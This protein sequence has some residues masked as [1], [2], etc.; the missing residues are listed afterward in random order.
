MVM[1]S[2]YPLTEESISKIPKGK[3]RSVCKADKVTIIYEPIVL[4]MWES[5][6]LKTLWASTTG[7]RDS[8]TI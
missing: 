5:R 8:F 4:E 1:E 2:T 6:H 3:F 7:Y